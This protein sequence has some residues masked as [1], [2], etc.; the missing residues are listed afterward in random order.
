MNSQ[1]QKLAIRQNLSPKQLQLM[2]LIQMP[3]LELNQAIMAEIEKNPMLELEDE[4]DRFE[5]LPT[6]TENEN[7]M[8]F[9]DDDYNEDRPENPSK[10]WNLAGEDSFQQTLQHQ[11]DM[12]KLSERERMLV[13]EI[14]G[15]LDD[16]GYLARDLALIQN[17]FAFQQG[18]EASNAEMDK[19]L[20]TVQSLDPA[21][22]GARTLRECLLLQLERIRPQTFVTRCA[23]AI[24]KDCFEAFSNHQ[25]EAIGQR[26]EIDTQAVSEAVRFIQ[27]QL[28]PKPCASESARTADTLTITPDLVV[29]RSQGRLIVQTPDRF[30]KLR[31]SH[32]YDDLLNSL[33]PESQADRETLEFLQSKR[34][35]AQ[36]FIENLQLRSQ[37]LQK[38][39]KIIVEQQRAYLLSG[40]KAD[41]KP[42]IQHELAEK[43]GMDDSTIS[44]IV[45]S[46][47]IQ[48]DFGIF[49]LSEFFSKSS[50]TADGSTVATKA[51]QDHLRE[52]IEKEDKAHPLS[53]D[54]LQEH[55]QQDGFPL[56]RRTVT[57][58]RTLLGFPA[59][60]LRRTL[61]T[62]MLLLLPL[63]A[64]T[65]EPM[66]YYDSLIY[67]Q[68]HPVQKTKA[69]TKKSTKTPDAN[70]PKIPKAAPVDSNL[71]KS[72]EAIDNYYKA[73]RPSRMWYGNLFPRNRVKPASFNI[74]S[75]PDAVNLRLVQN[76]SDFCF[77]VKN[78]ITSPYGWRWNRAHRGVDILLNTGDPVKCVFP[79]VVR[80]ASPMGGYGNLV[81]VRHYNGLETV[82]GHLSKILV[83]T[84]EEVPAGYVLGLGG[85]TGHSTGPHLHFE[86]RFEYEPFD[87]EWILD[88]KSYTLRTHR[89]HLDKTYFGIS[90][91]RDGQSS[92]YKAD[93]SYVKESTASDRKAEKRPIYYVMQ[94]D[95]NL[96]TVAQYYRTTPEKIRELN[97]DIKKIKK[98]TRLRVR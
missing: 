8:E 56:S 76:D 90:K 52:I 48:T 29:A 96:E 42:L 74:D 28:T 58:Y 94:K 10:G 93:K 97:P 2:N 12:L 35:D 84:N 30:P 70:K 1:T 80:I 98:G 16:A 44:R 88:F 75:L 89:L 40:D 9:M 53:D 15:S 77:P 47:Y 43:I 85:S 31:I 86:V 81:V 50:T 78:I 24:V 95:D 46:K 73:T 92:D 14:L 49:P 21:G 25:Y 39:S 69:S 45:N 19:A 66:S 72:D 60:K 5:S 55:M 27:K 61:L 54:Q 79:G 68:T 67:R 51:V 91:P 34:K 37:A 26:L 36:I 87:P 3:S 17:D 6:A 59:A 11:V 71:L 83:K 18:I 38:A 64:L 13:D 57:K 63:S 82:Y 62:L 41:L 20:E 65:Q 4:G 33:S 7:G 23:T 32:E 22:I